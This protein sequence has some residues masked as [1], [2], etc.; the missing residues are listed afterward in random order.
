MLQPMKQLES[1]RLALCGVLLWLGSGAIGV[2]AS[3]ARPAAG[4][5][6]VA[7]LVFDELTDGKCQILSE[8]GKL[9][10]LRNSHP[11]RAIRY[12]LM[13]M[14]Q[15]VPQS[16]LD[17]S[18]A[19]GEPPQKLGC[20]RVNGRGQYWRVERATLIDPSHEETH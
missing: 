19:P 18:I 20:N 6:A 9:V 17:G 1:G 12:R 14:F 3:S 10:V 16:R 11:E 8:G 2:P 5:G 15:E 13:R 7:W 4:A